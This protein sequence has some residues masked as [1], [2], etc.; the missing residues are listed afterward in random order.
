MA[1]EIDKILKL[2]KSFKVLKWEKLIITSSDAFSNVVLGISTSKI[3]T[4]T[5]LLLSII[6]YELTKNKEFKEITASFCCVFV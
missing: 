4:D 6:F 5:R 3:N 2:Q 1:R